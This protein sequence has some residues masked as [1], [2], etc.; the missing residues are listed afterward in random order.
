MTTKTV[1]FTPH[2]CTFDDK[3]TAAGLHAMEGGRVALHIYATNST[4][5][6]DTSV[7]MSADEARRL[8]FELL[9]H[10]RASE[11]IGNVEGRNEDN[12]EVAA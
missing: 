8:G 4:C 1:L 11:G 9:R 6:I 12:T 2:V 7:Y 5:G 3:S 10:A